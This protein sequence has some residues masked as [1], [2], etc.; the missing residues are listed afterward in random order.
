MELS[1][2]FL[3]NFFLIFRERYIQNRGIFRT[4]VYS[5]NEAY[6]EHCQTFTMECL[7]RIAT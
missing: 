7:T 2:I 3:K 4:L 6:S 1:Y 5:E